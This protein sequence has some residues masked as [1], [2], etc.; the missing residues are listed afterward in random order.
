VGAQ[1]TVLH[2][3]GGVS[4]TYAMSGDTVIASPYLAFRDA[5][6][7][8]NVYLRV[9][10]IG[11]PASAA[12][13]GNQ[14]AVAGAVDSMPDTSPVTSAVLNTPDAASTRS[15]FDQLSGDAVAST[16]G[17]LV[18]GSF[19]VRDTSF[20]RLR[21]VFCAGR[22]S[23]QPRP[24]CLGD[25]RAFWVQGFGDW[26]QVNGD[27]NAAGITRATG[28]FLIGYDVPV[29]DWRIGV[30]GG[31]SHTDV[32]S[33]TRTSAGVGN[34]YHLGAYGGSQF[35]DIGVRLGASYSWSDIS[36][37]RLVAF[38][39]FSNDLRARYN[40][41]TTQ[42]FGEVGERF[43][44][45]DIDLEP[46]ANLAYVNLNTPGFREYGGDAALIA[47]G[48]TV[49]DTF[50]TLGVRPSTSVPVGNTA[51]TLRGMLGWRHTF[52]DIA[53]VSRVAFAGSSTFSVSGAPIA[54]DAGVVELGVAG[55]LSPR[56]T[57]GLTYGGQFSSRE[58]GNGIRGTLNIAF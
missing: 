49:E 46:F 3:D 44:F 10:K 13:T 39:N 36:S 18:S 2:A 26:G 21:D 24:G 11:D 48:D 50:A 16:K 37:Q 7:A 52:G 8:N 20:D 55:N 14:A 32:D 57:L 54:E 12:T 41:G 47:Q 35:G 33:K 25:R 56:T 22:E 9:V 51:L 45:D 34:S 58:T 42:I 5:Y 6:D 4:G 1:Y 29:E 23:G 40:A 15:A 43:A 19:L 53:P 17:A 31:Y 30:F 38:G 28:G 27:G